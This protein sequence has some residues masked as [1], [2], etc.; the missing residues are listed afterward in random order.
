MGKPILLALIAGSAANT[1]EYR[2]DAEI[3]QRTM[4]ILK[5]VRTLTRSIHYLMQR[6]PL[7]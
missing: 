5:R 4:V 6:H 1:H 2:S 3:V 7:P